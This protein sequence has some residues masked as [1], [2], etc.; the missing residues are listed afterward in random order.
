METNSGR[1]CEIGSAERYWSDGRPRPSCPESIQSSFAGKIFSTA[2][3][4]SGQRVGHRFQQYSVFRAETIFAIA[5]HAQHS[6]LPR[7]QLDGNEYL[8]SGFRKRNFSWRIAA[9]AQR[10]LRL[11][12]SPPPGRSDP[13]IVTA[14]AKQIDHILQRRMMRRRPAGREQAFDVSQKLAGGTVNFQGRVLKVR[15]NRGQV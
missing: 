5:L 14:A 7:S 12:F 8:G 9:D 4:E 11:S 13:G 2:S 6:Q 3:Q 10:L 15:R 1:G